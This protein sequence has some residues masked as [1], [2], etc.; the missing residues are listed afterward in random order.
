M[1][2]VQNTISDYPKIDIIFQNYI[3]WLN[4]TY[5]FDHNCLTQKYPG[6]LN[7]TRAGAVM[8]CFIPS[9]KSGYRLQKINLP[10]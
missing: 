2:K 8:V 9:V 3:F 10:R 1:T 5:T 4:I 6:T 7:N